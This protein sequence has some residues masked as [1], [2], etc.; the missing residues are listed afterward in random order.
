MATED[1]TMATTTAAPKAGL[2]STFKRWLVSLGPGIITAA[3]VFG[4]SKVT[5]TSKMGAVYGYSLL[6]I[7][8]IAI[9]FMI[10]FT[11]MADRIGIALNQ[12]LLTTVRD[13]WGK[14]IALLLGIGV[15]LVTS[16]FQ[17]GN[18]IGVGISLAEA[19]HGSP[20]PWIIAF[21]IIG[22][23]LLFFR[24]FYKVLEKVMIFLVVLMLI[25]IDST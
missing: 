7:V 23:V 24:T 22:I 9:F 17:A 6:W 10:V 3:V 12:S 4:P 15:F 14:T 21:N 1:I 19:S 16:S 2:F 11:S 5:I 20:I 18:S 13:K 8:V 25:Y